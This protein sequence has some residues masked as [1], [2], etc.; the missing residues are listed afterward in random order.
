MN[1]AIEHITV[2]LTEHN[3]A[4]RS[5]VLMTISEFDAMQ[6]ESLE[7]KE[8]LK[9]QIKKVVNETLTEKTGFGGIED[10][11]FTSIVVQ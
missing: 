5:A 3:I 10:V 7:G 6:L 8:Q 4:V 11:Y 1:P 9:G 2:A